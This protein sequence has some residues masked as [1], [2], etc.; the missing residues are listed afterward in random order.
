MISYRQYKHTKKITQ[1]LIFGLVWFN[2]ELILTSDF[3]HQ[4]KHTKKY[5]NLN[6]WFRKLIICTFGV[7]ELEIQFDK[8]I[9]LKFNEQ[10]GFLVILL[11]KQFL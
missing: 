4:S 1:F 6:L 8:K 2:I 5:S 11:K 10:S 9:S 7:I 3:Y